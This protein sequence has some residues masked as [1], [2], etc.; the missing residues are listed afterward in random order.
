L[1]DR[2]DLAFEVAGR[3]KW[4]AAI[5]V[6]AAVPPAVPS[7]LF[8]VLFQ[9]R[10]L[11]DTF[12]GKSRVGP[13]V[14]DRRELLQH[15]NQE[16]RQ[17]YALTFPLRAHKIHPVVPVP[18][19]NQRQAVIAEPQTVLDCTDAMLIESSGLIRST[20]QVIICLLVRLDWAAL[21]ERNP[22]VE[23]ARVADLFDVLAC[24]QGQP[25]KVIGKMRAH[26]ASGGRMPPVLNVSLDK[27][28]ARGPQQ[29]FAHQ[30]GLCMHQGHDVLQLIAKP[31]RA[32]GLVISA[33]PPKTAGQGLV[34]QPTVDQS[35]D[36]LVRGFHV[37]SAQRS[38]PVMP[39]A[40]QGSARRPS[41]SIALDQSARF[42]DA[43]SG[44]QKKHNLTFLAW[45]NVKLRLHRATR[46][47]SRPDLSRKSCPAHSRW[48]G[49]RAIASEEFG[50]VAG[51]C[52]VRLIEIE[53]GNPARK[54]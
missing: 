19:T 42:L 6:S 47:E 28:M 37:D 43:R 4:L 13:Q 32:P 41:A 29:M 35:V 3:A 39:H 23:Y 16:E 44:S 46:I 45:C 5:E 26:A 10:D 17:P 49:C 31:E 14:S 2:I 36:T 20:R 33:T 53:K 54:L 15:V 24:S 51:N 52:A 48:F 11:G 1:G 34:E 21:D 9:L 27:L 50:T 30:P 7:V 18:A 25:Q 22:L 40:F 38:L 8:D 12:L